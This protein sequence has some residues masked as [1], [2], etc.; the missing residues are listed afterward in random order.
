MDLSGPLSFKLNPSDRWNASLYNCCHIWQYVYLFNMFLGFLVLFAIVRY[1]VLNLDTCNRYRKWNIMHMYWYT[2][3]CYKSCSV[4]YQWSLH[5][6]R[7]TSS[8]NMIHIAYI[9]YT[10]INTSEFML[11]IHWMFRP[12]FQNCS[13]NCYILTLKIEIDCLQNSG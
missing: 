6:N 2:I 5:P 11:F 12:L 9:T 10:C 8:S 13:Y 3:H 7:N 1:I 4:G